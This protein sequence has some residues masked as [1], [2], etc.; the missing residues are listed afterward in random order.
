LL[1]RW[2]ETFVEAAKHGNLTNASHV[3]NI[4]Q[5]AVSHQLKLLQVEL[6]T[7]L[8]K[9]NPQGI[10]LT[11]HGR[12]VLQNS[13][14]I[15]RQIADLRERLNPGAPILRI[16]GSYSSTSSMPSLLAKIKKIYPRVEIDLRT[17]NNHFLS[18]MVID[19]DL[20]IA[21]VKS[22]QPSPL[23]KV[24]TYRR[25]QL[26]IFGLPSHP[27]MRKGTITATELVRY[28]FVIRHPGNSEGLTQQLLR[29]LRQR[30]LKFHVALRCQTPTAVTEA[31]RKKM[32]LG[33]LYRSTVE[34]DIKRGDFSSVR[35]R[36]IKLEGCSYIIYRGDNAFSPWALAFLDLLRRDKEF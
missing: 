18:Q 20:E 4:T 10:E 36:E 3:L 24:E 26:V 8:F 1:L 14:A 29:E 21:V 11:K 6:G 35:C 25:E 23:L 13:Q 31:V 28:P 19:G 27:L 5:P 34:A 22:T 15:L 2:I 12:F 32:G 7:T 30:G 33:I 17:G 9:R 16:G